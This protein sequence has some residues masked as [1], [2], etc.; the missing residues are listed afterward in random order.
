[1]RYGT[2]N[3]KR[4]NTRLFSNLNYNKTW[5]PPDTRSS[6]SSVTFN[7]FVSCKTSS[8]IVMFYKISS[9]LYQNL[10]N[11]FTM[12]L[13]VQDFRWENLTI[14]CQDIFAAVGILKIIFTF[15]ITW[16]LCEYIFTKKLTKI[17]NIARSKWSFH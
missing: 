4:L 7:S 16:V 9:A 17:F 13:F 8:W 1:M 15:L 11:K 12:Y 10:I 5:M 2:N 14:K 6:L 3:S